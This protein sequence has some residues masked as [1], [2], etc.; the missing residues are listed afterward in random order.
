MRSFPDV[1]FYAKGA[2]T[3]GLR[4]VSTGRAYTQLCKAVQYRVGL[5]AVWGFG[6]ERLTAEDS[7]LG[8]RR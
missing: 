5:S 8:Q 7:R 4:I 2:K 6:E 3:P 1:A